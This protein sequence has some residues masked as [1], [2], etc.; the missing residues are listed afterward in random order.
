MRVIEKKVMVAHLPG[1]APICGFATY[2][3]ADSPVLL[4]RCGWEIADDVHDDFV[5]V[6]SHDNGK[7]WDQGRV[8]LKSKPVDGGYVAY[9]ENAALFVPERNKLVLFTDQKFQPTMERHDGG[10]SSVLLHITAADPS[11]LAAG[12]SEPTVVSDFGFKQG[13][14]VSFCHPILDSVGRVLAPVYMQMQDDGQGSLRRRGCRVRDDLSDV[15]L[16]VWEPRLLIGEFAADGGISWH[17]GEP[18]P[19]DLEKTFYLC[20]GTVAE[21][22]DGRL[23]MILRGTNYVWPDRPGYKWLSYSQDGGHSWSEALPLPCDD[24]G[25]IESS[26]TGSALFRSVKNG[27]LYWIGN[28]CTHGRRPDGNMPRSPLVVCEMEEDAVAIK[29]KTIVEIDRRQPGEHPDV[30]HSNFRFYQDRLTGD[31]VLYL[32][33]Y[34]ERGHDE[35]RWMAADNYQYR[36]AL[37]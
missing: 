31:I 37:D 19:F 10:R 26:A 20:E 22:R 11:E 36:I 35:N 1:R 33:R 4:R 23:A 18:V 29:R 30:Q 16:D 8:S 15:L 17:L 2:M 24:G 28:L 34:G 21:L 13:V 25:V 14:A 9:V 12:R 3:S 6:V 32:T 7:T 5:D 27:K